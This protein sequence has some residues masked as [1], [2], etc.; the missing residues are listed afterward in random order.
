[1]SDSPY[2]P[3]YPSDWLAGTRGLTAAETGV[4]ITLV[5][6]MYERETPIDTPPERLARLC[7]C[8]PAACRKALATLIDEGKLIA[9]GAGLWNARVGIEIEKRS[10]KRNSARASAEKR[11]GKT[12]EKQQS[13]DAN[14]LRRHC[15][16]N[17]NQNQSQK[18][19]K[20]SPPCSPPRLL[21]QP[22]MEASSD[23]RPGDTGQQ[24]ER[25]TSPPPPDH[26]AD[27]A[28][29][30][31][32]GGSSGGSDGAPGG[33][34][35]SDPGDGPADRLPVAGGG[36]RPAK[37]KRPVPPDWWPTSA[38]EAYADRHGCVDLDAAVAHYRDKSRAS[39]LYYLDFNAGWRT[40]C[41]KSRMYHT[42]G[43]EP[44]D[45]GG[46]SADVH[47]SRNSGSHSQQSARSGQFDR[48]LAASL[49]A[50]APRQQ[51]GSDDF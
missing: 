8:T 49:K 50:G 40:W 34:S 41:Q 6:L 11:W 36:G 46:G 7:G 16:R 33:D 29:E 38:G 32:A 47:R 31:H 39:G 26:E 13:G 23:E 9:T 25:Y 42:P 21:D 17:A 37:R 24:P 15:G 19:P 12:E 2:V 4:Y 35:Q 28:A 18:E 20:G 3:F 27:A 45:G 14:A 48:L 1:M 5:A 22:T 43:F 44:P 10:E 30:T 51:A